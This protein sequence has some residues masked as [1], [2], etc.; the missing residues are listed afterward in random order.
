MPRFYSNIDDPNSETK[1]FAFGSRKK[2]EFY[3][4]TSVPLDDK[5]FVKIL[6]ED[7]NSGEIF[8]Y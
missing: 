3:M 7:A 8:I 1:F 6:K 2:E 4:E 5:E